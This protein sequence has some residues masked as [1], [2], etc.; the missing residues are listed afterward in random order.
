MARNSNSVPRETPSFRSTSDLGLPLF[1]AVPRYMHFRLLPVHNSVDDV[2]SFPQYALANVPTSSPPGAVACAV[3][4]SSSDL[5][6]IARVGSA[7]PSR[8]RGNLGAEHPSL[9]YPRRKSRPTL[10]GSH[11]RRTARGRE[12]RISPPAQQHPA[13]PRRFAGHVSS[14]RRALSPGEQSLRNRCSAQPS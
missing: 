14:D 7:T 1:F 8:R 5:G 6:R 11:A 3:G 9:A 4:L 10:H 13:I 2:H 12:S